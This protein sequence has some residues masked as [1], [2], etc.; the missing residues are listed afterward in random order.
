MKG[1]KGAD[2]YKMSEEFVKKA[3]LVMR[4]L[5]RIAKPELVMTISD[6]HKVSALTHWQNYYI[7]GNFTAKSMKPLVRNP[8]GR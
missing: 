4:T 1:V 5:K 8:D 6:K 7:T 3:C 2:V